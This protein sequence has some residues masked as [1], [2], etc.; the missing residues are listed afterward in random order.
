M[1]LLRKKILEEGQ[2]LNEN[3]LKVDS[4]LNHGVDPK[5]MKEIGFYFKTYFKEKGITKVFTIESSGI[6]PAV[7]TALHMDLPMVT[8][9]KQT[10]KILKDDVYQTTVHSF[11]KGLDYELTLSKKYISADDNILVIDDF[12]ANGEAAL[13]AARLIENAGAKVGGIGI[14]IEKSFQKGREILDG[15]GYD[16]YSLARIK[17]LR[18]GEIEFIK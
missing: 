9:K 11:T 2:A 14:V 5:L 6:A 15:K 13:G 7:M 1:E 12:L 4:F 16:V 17:R 3:V 10:S 8:L 18:K